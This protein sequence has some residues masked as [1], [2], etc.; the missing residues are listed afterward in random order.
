MILRSRSRH[1]EAKT[2][3]RSRSKKIA[4]VTGVSFLIAE[5]WLIVLPAMNTSTDRIFLGFPHIPTDHYAYT[6]VTSQASETDAIFYKNDF[7][8]TPHNARFL[9]TALTATGWLT[10]LTGAPIQWVWHGLRILALALFLFTLFRLF[11][12]IFPTPER[13]LTAF[14]FAIF[15]GGLDWGFRLAVRMNWMTSPGVDWWGV[16]PWNFSIF[17]M[18]TIATW[19][20]PLTVLL[21]IVQ[22]E[23]SNPLPAPG[24]SGKDRF[25]RAAWPR[26][27]WR[28]TMLVVLFSLHPYS[29][30]MYGLMIIV[31]S[32]ADMLSGRG[33]L[34][35]RVVNA[36]VDATPSLLGVIVILA[37]I[38]WAQQDPVFASSTAQT[39]L[40]KAHY[41]VY[42]YPIVYGPQLFLAIF[43]VF[44]PRRPE[45]SSYNKDISPRFDWIIAWAL[46]AGVMSFNPLVTG[47]KFQVLFTIPLVVLELRGAFRVWEYSK[48]RWTTVGT[49]GKSTKTA[50]T[51]GIMIFAGANSI[52]G[53]VHD[54][55]NDATKR[56]SEADPA[57][58]KALATL[59][60]LPPGGVMTDQ[61][62]GLLVPWL[63]RHPVFVGHWF[64]STRFNEKGT[65]VHWFFE[66]PA[67]PEQR[68]D[69]LATAHIDYIFYTPNLAM[70]GPPPNLDGLQLIHREGA[71]SI[72]GKMPIS[73][74]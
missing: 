2:L 21:A 10:R 5:I 35:S 41:P 28:G 31:M 47:V 70:F 64:L 13:A 43:G 27:F 67:T 38:L 16:N 25:I 26:A 60:E 32:I 50:L 6:M 14:T 8:T 34:A 52:D 40:W 49:F 73:G 15:S 68:L 46:V 23:T 1:D 36:L 7:T 42:L 61:T 65:L 12:T 4:L 63:G 3:T 39:S 74:P 18:G 57:L 53:L 17:W 30:I 20:W 66:G 9:M 48:A 19:V 37:Y 51:V 71:Y 69:F 54:S 72:W 56:A 11:E 62:S 29:A 22:R 58:V 59:A 33:S 55:R 24:T 45:S 44:G